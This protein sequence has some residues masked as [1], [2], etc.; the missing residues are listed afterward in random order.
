MDDFKM[1]EFE[2]MGILENVLF[3]LLVAFDWNNSCNS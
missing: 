3:P 1:P 2:F